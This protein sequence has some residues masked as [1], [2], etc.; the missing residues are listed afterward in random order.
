[1]KKIISLFCLLALLAPFTVLA[2][3]G[4]GET[5]GFTITHYFVEPIHA[6]ASIGIIASVVFFIRYQNRK[7]QNS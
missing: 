2:H 3:P 6:V 1:M 7:R 4:H 5:D